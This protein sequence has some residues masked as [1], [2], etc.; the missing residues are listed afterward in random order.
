MP[1]ISSHQSSTVT[2]LLY[3]GDS[4]TGKT[5][6]LAALAAAGYRLR[7][8][9][10]DNGLDVLRAYL[11]DPKS[12]YLLANPK[13]AEN[14]H[15]V[16][17]T[18]KMRNINGRITPATARVWP[19]VLDMLDHWRVK[20]T[21]ASGKTILTEGKP[22]YAEDLGKPTSWGSQE[23]LVL[24]TLT[25]LGTAAYNYHCSMNGRLGA[26]PQ[27]N[28][29]R[30]DIGAT[31]SMLEGLL[32]L[33]SDTSLGCNVILNS[34]L[35]YVQD[36]DAPAMAD[37]TGGLKTG[38]PSAIGKALSPKIPRYFNTVLLAKTTG[39]GASTKHKIFTSSQGQVD[40]KST[41]PL[42]VAKEYDLATGLADYFKAVR[43]A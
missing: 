23:V 1:P 11:T 25:S 29:W 33:L 14:V 19:Q 18:E 7:I 6:S 17:L 13:A 43:Q 2:K 30:R 22:T 24:D 9:D 3:C 35:T 42:R 21:D 8:I 28:E 39:F 15:F 34:H 20:D 4:G 12:Q 40:L 27:G 41:N 26:S 32:Q 10:T 5:G 31:Q 16:T 37:G 38:Y 36:E